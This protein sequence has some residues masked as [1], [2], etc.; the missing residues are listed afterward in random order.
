MVMMKKDGLTSGQLLGVFV[1]LV[2]AFFFTSRFLG[3][4][5]N[6]QNM[7]SQFF[8]T[9]TN[10][11]QAYKFLSYSDGISTSNPEE[12]IKKY[13]RHFVV[14]SLCLSAAPDYKKYCASDDRTYKALVG[15]YSPM[16]ESVYDAGQ[17]ALLDGTLAMFHKIDN[18]VILY[19]DINGKKAKPNRLGIDVFA[20]L[21][22]DY[23][24]NL[25]PMG[26]PSTPYVSLSEYCNPYDA[27]EGFSG[28][29]CTYA[30]LLDRDYFETMLDKVR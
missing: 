8:K 29:S 22:A 18:G 30:A 7:K 5:M 19:V 25:V 15:D 4:K 1:I 12:F 28:I 6:P 11:S 14:K 24:D 13:S 27:K 16:N 20:F 17:F 26:D 3:K 23:S 9:Y 21:I 10:F 2:A